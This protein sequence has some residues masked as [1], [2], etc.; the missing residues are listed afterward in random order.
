MLQETKTKKQAEPVEIASNKQA[1]AFSQAFLSA[2]IDYAYNTLDDHLKTKRLEPEVRE[3]LAAMVQLI[4]V[5]ELYK[6]QAQVDYVWNDEACYAIATVSKAVPKLGGHFT[7]PSG[8]V[9]K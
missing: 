4:S 9:L 1:P 5:R 2:M 3:L 6:E 7:A 8:V